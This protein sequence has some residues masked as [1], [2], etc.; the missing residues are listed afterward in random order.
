MRHSLWLWAGLWLFAALAVGVSVVGYRWTR[1]VAPLPLLVGPT[2]LPSLPPAR[3]L[4]LP[5][6]TVAERDI[7]AQWRAATGQDIERVVAP[8]GG[9][10]NLDLLPP[11][12]VGATWYPHLR[13][14]PRHSGHLG[15]A[16]GHMLAWDKAPNEPFVVLEDDAILAPRLRHDLPLAL[17]AVARWDPEWDILLLGYSCSYGSDERCHRNDGGPLRPVQAAGEWNDDES[18]LHLQ[19]LHYFFGLWGYVVNGARAVDRMMRAVLP[20]QWAVDL[21]LNRAG[22]LG[23]YGC[24]PHLVYHPGRMEVSPHYVH[25]GPRQPGRDHYLSSTHV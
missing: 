13:R 19:R 9:W 1:P 20:F 21:D 12:V 5:W 10:L 24:L 4:N 6:A 11:T 23:I 25:A 18:P 16:L 15:A 22:T 7:A 2:R 17:A 8:V 14:T 3:V